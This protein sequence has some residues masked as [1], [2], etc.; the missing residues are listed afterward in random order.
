MFIILNKK[1]EIISK[2][3][4]Y[5]FYVNNELREIFDFNIYILRDKSTAEVGKKILK[6]KI[7]SYEDK[8]A[9]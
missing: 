7:K 4:I 8:Q 9:N 1:V 2:N 3:N 6:T 5:Y